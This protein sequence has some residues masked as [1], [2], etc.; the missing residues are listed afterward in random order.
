MLHVTG[1]VH[2]GIGRQGKQHH[3]HT[4]ED[5][6]HQCSC[7]KASG[8][9]PPQ[10]PLREPLPW[11]ASSA[12]APQAQQ[13]GRGPLSLQPATAAPPEKH[14]CAAHCRFE[15]LGLRHARLACSRLLATHE[16]S[17]M[18]HSPQASVSCR[19][20]GCVRRFPHRD[21]ASSIVQT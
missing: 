11:T 8:E 4:T 16:C 19:G 9:A 12:A 15:S 7:Q 5:T 6:R 14:R 3:K 21:D 13:Q 2:M 17:P 18:P 1:W 10:W 20:L